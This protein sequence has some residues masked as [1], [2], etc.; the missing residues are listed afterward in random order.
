MLLIDRIAAVHRA[1]RYR[2]FAERDELRFLL[3]RDLEGQ[4]AVDIGAN[5]GV[6]SYWMHKKVGPRGHVVAFEPQSELVAYLHDYKRTFELD[7]LTIVGSA[8]SCS[9]GEGQLV[10]PRDHWGRASLEMEPDAN[11]DVLRVAL[12]TLDEFFVHSPLRPLRFVKCDVEGHEFDVFRGGELVLREDQPDLLFE[13]EDLYVRDGNLFQYLEKLGYRG[14]FFRGGEM[15]PVSRYAELR[16]RIP[17]SYLNYVFVSTERFPASLPK[18]ASP[19]PELRTHGRS[20]ILR[21]LLAHG[22]SPSREI[23]SRTVCASRVMQ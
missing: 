1:W 20:T 12:M 15:T 23:H 10:R 17:R 5:R 14:F 8:L 6:Y 4:T 9:S 2:L 7:R 3:Q 18:L 19:Q 11:T 16:A 22:R 13:G 21:D